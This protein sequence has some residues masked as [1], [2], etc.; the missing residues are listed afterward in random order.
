[1]QQLERREPSLRI[2]SLDSSHTNHAMEETF[3]AAARVASLLTEAAAVLIVF[4]G[5][6]EAFASLLRIVFTPGTTH[7]E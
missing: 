4:Y 1:L 6:V 2:P 3:A 5:A 7:G